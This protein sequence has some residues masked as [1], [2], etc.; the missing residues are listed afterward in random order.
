MNITGFL[1]SQ[2]WLSQQVRWPCKHLLTKEEEENEAQ[3]TPGVPLLGAFTAYFLWDTFKRC[4]MMLDVNQ[5]PGSHAGGVRSRGSRIKWINREHTE[6]PSR[7]DTYFWLPGRYLMH[8]PRW[9]NS[10]G[11]LG[12]HEPEHWDMLPCQR[13]HPWWLVEHKDSTTKILCKFW[14]PKISTLDSDTP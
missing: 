10:V 5:S 7:I 13:W 6:L 1:F 2:Q 14:N 11:R 4:L 9:S 12:L 3:N 8:S